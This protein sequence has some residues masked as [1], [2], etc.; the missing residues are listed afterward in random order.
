MKFLLLAVLLF[1][2]D[3][4]EVKVE[5]EAKDAKIDL[6][7][8]TYVTVKID[9]AETPDLRDRFVGFSLAEDYEVS[10]GVTSWRLVPR[11]GEKAYKLLPFAVGNY[12]T[13]AVYFEMP[14]A[15]PLVSGEMEV[16]VKK[17]FPPLSWKLV[18]QVSLALLSAALL[19]AALI[20][21]I[22]LITRRVK[23]HFMSPIE[24]AY[25]E[26]DRLLKKDFVKKGLFKD[27]Y[28]ELTLVVR[29]YIQRKFGIKAPHMTTEEF[30]KAAKPSDE[31]REFLESADLIKFAGVEASEK[32][33]AEATEK[34][35]DY[36]K[37]SEEETK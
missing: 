19:I 23:E 11:P 9:G 5:I 7:R 27:F 32:T 12:L 1:S 3:K 4:G 37:K 8:S 29:R 33:A 30:L 10:P 20:Y 31:L 13:K 28:V 25:V 17:D 34:A 2:L 22:K 24:R 16:V 35:R 21:L 15:L 36:L 14:E 26:L 6:A 18:G